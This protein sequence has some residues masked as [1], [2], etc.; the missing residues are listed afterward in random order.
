MDCIANKFKHARSFWFNLS[1][2]VRNIKRENNNNDNNKNTKN[3]DQVKR[4]DRIQSLKEQIDYQYEL[5]NN[6][7]AEILKDELQYEI[8]GEIIYAHSL[9]QRRYELQVI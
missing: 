6:R 8:D 7:L 9:Y 4:K 2:V 5:G 1:P 3:E